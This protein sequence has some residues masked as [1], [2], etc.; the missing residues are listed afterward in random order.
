MKEIMISADSPISIYLVP[1][2][3]AENLREYC[4]EFLDELYTFSNNRELEIIDNEHQPSD[5]E[6]AVQYDETGFIYWL[7][8]KKFP[9]QKSSLVRTM[10]WDEFE[11]GLKINAFDENLW[12]NF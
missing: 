1:D 10:T 7:N 2:E 5:Q 11:D 9:N 3:V 12:F 4:M 6:E 8:E